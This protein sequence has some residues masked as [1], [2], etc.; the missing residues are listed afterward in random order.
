MLDVF[1]L[2]AIGSYG[3]S[4]VTPKTG[5]RTPGDGGAW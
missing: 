3:T 4:L 5:L 1:V 2:V